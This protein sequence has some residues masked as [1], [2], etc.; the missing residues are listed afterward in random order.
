[1]PQVS[2]EFEVEDPEAVGA[3]AA[4][5]RAGGFELLHDARQEPWGQTVARLQSLEFAIVG[6]SFAPWLHSTG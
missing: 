6:I 2:L 3:A 4:E 1:V 5:L